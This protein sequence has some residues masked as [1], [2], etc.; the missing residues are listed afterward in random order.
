LLDSIG[1]DEQLRP[2]HEMFY[3][4]RNNA[5]TEKIRGY[6]QQPKTYFVVVGAAHLVGDDG[7]VKQLAA[8]PAG[9]SIRQIATSAAPAGA[10]QAN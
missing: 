9:L 6:L 5:M 8:A 7:I 1:E 4:D 2:I 10:A 3:T